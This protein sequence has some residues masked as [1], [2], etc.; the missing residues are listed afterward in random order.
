MANRRLNKKVALIGSV[1]VAVFIV[2]VILVILHLSRDPAEFI[3]DAEAALQAARQATDEQIK[4][5]NYDRAQSSFRGAY[6]SAKTNPLREEILF[7][8]VD[9]YLEIKEW[10][11]ILSCWDEII[12]IDP[13]NVKACYGRLKY[14]Y[15]M[16]DSGA[17]LMSVGNA[18]RIWQEVHKQAS[19]FLKVAENAELLME[20]TAR[21]DVFETESEVRSQESEDRSQQLLGPYLYLLRGR[22]ALEMASLGAVTNRD[23]SLAQAVDDLKKVQ[24]LEPNNIDAYWYLARAA[25]T[26]GEIFASRGNFEERDKAAEQA[27]VLFEQAVQIAGTE[28][29]VSAKAR[30]VAAKAH[31]NLLALKLMLAKGS[32]PELVNER[33]RALEPEYLSLVRNFGSS[34]EAFAAISQFY[35]VYSAYSGPRLVPENL[36][37]A[38]EAIEQA[39]RLDENSVVYAINAANLHY[40]RFS[41]YKQKQQVEKA[42][43]T[44]KNALTL[45][46]AQDAPG[47]RRQAKINNR[48]IL[49]AFLAN[50]YIEQILE[51]CEPQ[52]QSQTDV[53]LAGAEQAVHEIEQISGSGEEP[54]VIKWRGMLELAKG[55]REA[56]IRKLYAAYEKLKALKPPEP[57]WPSEPQFAQLSYTLAK[58]FKD[59]SEVGAV[60][61]FLISA[62]NSGIGQTKPE[63]HL[64]YFEVIL[65]FTQWSDAIETINAFEEYFGPNERSQEL[66]IKAYIGAKQFDDAEKELANRPEDEPNTIKL[67]LVLA[68]ARI[69]QIQLTMAQKEIRESSGL[70]SQQTGPEEKEPVEL[71]TDIRLMT[72]EL[73]SYLQLEAELLEKLL[74]IEPN[75]VEQASVIGVCRNYISQGRAG[76]AK[77]LVNGF[78]ERFPDNA[79]V[80]VYK[81]ILSEPDPAKISQQR[82]KEIGEQVLSNIP[83][84]IRRATQLGIFYRGYNEPEKAA[85]Q[86]NRAIEIGT[87]QSRPSDGRGVSDGPAFEQMKFAAS[88]LLDIALVA[89]DWELAEQ[90]TETTR[91]ENLDN[92]Q[93]LFFATRLAMAKGEFEDA[94]AKIDECLRQRPVFS[95]AYMLRS[96]INAY[97]GNEHASMEDIRKAASLNPLDGVIAKAS[98]NVLYRRNQKLGDSVSSAQIVEVR[99]ALE[100]AIAL[101]PGDLTLLGL[102]AEYIAPTEPLR[103]V[104]IRQDLQ[105]A[106]PNMDNALLLGQLATQVAVKETNPQQKEALFGIAASAFEQAKKINPSDKL[107]LYHYAQYF[108]ARGQNEKAKALLQESQDEKLLWD[109]YFQRGQYDDAGRVLEQLYEG[110]T[111]DSVVLKGLLLVAEK[112]IDREAVKKYSEELVALDEAVENNLIQIEAFLR[113]GLI[114]EAEYKLQ[115]FKEKYPNEKRILL[116]Q[117]WLLMRQGQLDKALELTNKNLQTNQNNPAAWRLRGEINFLLADYGKAISDF[118]ESKLLSDEPVTRISLA[119]AYMGAGRYEDAITELEVTINAPG[120]PPEALVLL[121]GIYSQLDRQEALKRFYKETLEEFPD[122]V[123]WLN[124]AGAFAVKRGEF[125]KAEQLYKKAYL[126]RQQAHLAKDERNEVQDVL[127]VTAFDGFLKALLLGAGE[128]NTDNWNPRKLDQVFEECSKYVDSSI[129]PIAY[130]RMAQAKLKLGDRTTAVEY[131]R[132]AVDKA[133]ENETFASEVL[134]RMFLMLGP[135]EV[136]KYCRQKLETNPN[137]LAANF[138]MFNLAK[139][140]N[141]YEKAIGYIDKCIEPAEPDSPGRANYTMKK[142]DVLTLAYKKSS[143]KNYLR[144][145]ITVYK[146]LLTKMPNNTSILN[147][148]AYLLAENNERLPEALLYAKRALGTQPNNPG[149]LDT[150]AYVLHKQG[151]NSQ[152]AEFLA[153]ALQQYQQNDILVPAEVY[154]HK[155][156]IKEKLGAKDEAVAAYRQALEIGAD[157]LS[158]KAEQRINKAIERLSP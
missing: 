37:K 154:E 132:R 32:E 85:R 36:D 111:K 30:A 123:R 100:R 1:I 31:V 53:W 50:C 146:S 28:P 78:L 94:L 16:A 136:L 42:I 55:N 157:R 126:L 39:I 66:R 101:N 152:A 33:I 153:A 21:W 57:P 58:I 64:D 87:S 131:C 59:T 140:N 105:R 9:M 34:A 15:I 73:K 27:T 135:D 54:L 117:A 35:S 127:Y 51:P 112:T 25:V 138:A 149:F 63:A 118:R 76:R 20:D 106:A 7:K 2:V 49:Y 95:Y 45:P 26:K 6:A 46:D 67:R 147:N 10:P 70:V 18:G 124:Q 102:Y 83:D 141:E 116:L 52:S 86:L 108:R 107:M 11:Y 114:K 98:A 143:D 77:S 155:G 133:G 134:L 88:H 74:L 81:Q 96:D 144:T 92:C 113:V 68:Q 61:E 44:A 71:T 22:A 14:L 5:Q 120:A 158:Q 4:Q 142:A 47:P 91:R 29:L 40:R 150:Y 43:E 119:K 24:E 89:K 137:S 19:E 79:A 139:L 99:S 41:I 104:A 156:M 90:I 97:L 13:N 151:E 12:R 8:M 121:E 128:P 48:F 93:G 80:L 62:L 23:E 17:R 56:A 115:S 38:I 84:P 122:S 130:L 145:A 60:R 109:H 110:G 125:D 72:E 129:A 69:R 148:L 82:R 103:A 75:S 3:K 65:K